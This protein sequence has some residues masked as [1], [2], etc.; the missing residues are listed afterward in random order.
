M[1]DVEGSGK[2]IQ[3]ADCVGYLR[4][5]AAWAK[6]EA[7]IPVPVAWLRVLLNARSVDTEIR[8][9]LTVKEV[10]NIIGRAPPTIR[11]WL[12]LGLV[13]GAYRLRG[14]EWR[15]PRAGLQAIRGVDASI[16]GAEPLDPALVHGRDLSAW[17]HYS[18]DEESEGG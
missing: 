18:Q 3:A 9:D 6:P 5:I 10:A 13:P 1:S 12:R 16:A 2:E 15:I 11:S 14:R 7:V 8:S 17:R 4:A